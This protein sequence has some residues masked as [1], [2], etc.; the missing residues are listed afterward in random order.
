M[1]PRGPFAKDEVGPVWRLV[2]GFGGFNIPAN[3]CAG[4]RAAGKVGGA[5]RGQGMAARDVW[6]LAHG[7][8]DFEFGAA[9]FLD[10]KHVAMARFIFAGDVL[11]LN[12]CVAQVDGAGDLELEVESPQWIEGCF[13][14]LY[15]IAGGITHSVLQGVGDTLG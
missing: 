8:A 9:E 11:E 14:G 15:L 6:P 3:L 4:K 2:G 13:A 1:P 7:C 5:D 12:P 10:L